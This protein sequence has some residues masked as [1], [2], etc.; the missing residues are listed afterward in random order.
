MRKPR[1]PRITNPWLI[2]AQDSTDAVPYKDSL[3]VH[4]YHLKWYQK[5]KYSC[6][7]KKPR[8]W[9]DKAICE[10]H[11]LPVDQPRRIIIEVRLLMSKSRFRMEAIALKSRNPSCI[12]TNY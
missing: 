1:L 7:S 5:E 10:W 3:S 6:G 11:N 12:Q 9:L 4:C 8:R 2:T